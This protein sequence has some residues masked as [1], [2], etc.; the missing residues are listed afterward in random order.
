MYK[1]IRIGKKTDYKVG[2]G[3]WAPV[4]I[5]EDSKLKNFTKNVNCVPTPWGIKFDDYKRL[6]FTVNLGGENTSKW[7]DLMSM[8]EA[9]RDAV[10][11]E[12]IKEI[13]PRDFAL[14]LKDNSSSEDKFFNLHVWD[15]PTDENDMDNRQ[16]FTKFWDY[17][18]SFFNTQTSQ[19]E[20]IQ[21]S[22]WRDVKPDSVISFSFNL[23][24]YCV[25]TKRWEAGIG[26]KVTEVKILE[27]GVPRMPK[28][29]DEELELIRKRSKTEAIEEGEILQDDTTL[30]AEQWEEMRN[31]GT[32]DHSDYE[33]PIPPKKTP[34]ANGQTKE[35]NIVCGT[36]RR[37]LEKNTQINFD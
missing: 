19:I 22:D 7:D 3:W 14:P 9:I 11:K 15:K 37:F 13:D 33:I 27:V 23:S 30:S 8:F 17:S 20:K 1:D 28:I 2:T 12:W 31:M 34:F 26:M 24:V 4:K 25:K 21:V 18:Q 29:F 10:P 6:S 5:E 16:I 35:L 32:I 36:E